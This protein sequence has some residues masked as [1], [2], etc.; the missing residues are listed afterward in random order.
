MYKLTLTYPERQAIIQVGGRYSHGWALYQL[1]QNEEVACECPAG[2]DSELID[3]D[4]EGSITF[5]VP[6]HL[7]WEMKDLIEEDDCALLSLK[8]KG[9]LLDFIMAIV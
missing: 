8:L 2:L 7:A 5:D 3:W 6:E 4:Y 9:K 1:L